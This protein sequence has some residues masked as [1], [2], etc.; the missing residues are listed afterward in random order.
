MCFQGISAN[1][2]L[3]FWKTGL[4]SL[5]RR[6]DPDVDRARDSV[7]DWS[8]RY[9]YFEQLP[10]MVESRLVTRRAHPSLPLD[11]YNYTIQAQFMDPKAWT[12][13]LKDCRGLIL[14]HEGE[15]V[16]RPFRKFWNYE[17]VLDQVPAEERFT[18]WEKVDGSL[19]IVCSY[20][21][22]RVVA[23][24][25]SFESDQAKWFTAW[26]D[27][28]SPDFYPSGETWLFEI[29]YPEN[30]IVVD[31]GDTKEAFLLAVMA[32]DGVDLS[33]VFA[34]TERFRKAR[35]FDGITDFGVVNADPQFAGQEGFVV[36]WESG[37][38]AKIKAE[39][40][41]RLHRLITQCSTRTIWEMLRTGQ[42]TD[43]LLDRVPA[44]F[45]QWATSQINAIRLN[46]ATV[47]AEAGSAFLE[48]P[49]WKTRKD[50][51]L[52]AKQ[53]PN[54]GLLFSLL[55]GKDITDACWKLVEPKWAT[56]FRTDIDG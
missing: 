9:P 34:I 33:V 55:D 20:D 16:G 36:Q 1:R 38:R 40:Y 52:W 46:Y 7:Y 15:I 26:L 4:D 13:P 2:V 29:V 44:D 31:Y 14:N 24:R 19:G 11:I 27:R 28:K 42:S 50:F 32:P 54:P 35:R 30:R 5:K 45:K 18:V 39:E 51:A 53:Q 49:D 6:P 48:A 10:A 56:P 23:T 41:K 47:K 3:L 12:E 22:Q 25:G 8:M 37:L 43:E 21:G 17:Q